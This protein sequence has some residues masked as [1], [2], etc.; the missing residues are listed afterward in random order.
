MIVKNIHV[1]GV[2]C[3]SCLFVL[4]IKVQYKMKEAE[5]TNKQPS[6]GRCCKKK[7]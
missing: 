3:V 7:P 4:F 6:C 5:V 2:E 1:H